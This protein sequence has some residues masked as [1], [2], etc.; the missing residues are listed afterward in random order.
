MSRYRGY[1]WKRYVPV[2][3]R[4][5]KAAKKL[6]KLRKDGLDVRPVSI[7]G[8]KIART[9]WGKAWC[10]HLESF[11][12]FANRLPRGRTYVRNG[13]VCHLGLAKGEIT[14]L[15]SGSELYRVEVGIKTLATATWETIK[16]RCAGQIG[17]ILE[18]LQGRLSE[19]VMKIVSDR[20]GGLFPRP[21][22]IS[23]Q[24][25]CPDW[26]SMCKHV[27]AVLYGV[28]ARLDES[29]ELLFL[30]RGVDQGELIS[31]EIDLAGSSG[32]EKRGGK[33][34][35]E[36][37]L[38]DVFGIE[39]ADDEESAVPRPAAEASHGVSTVGESG[40]AAGSA[41]RGSDA[42]KRPPAAVASGKSPAAAPK[43][44]PTGVAR[45]RARSITASDV[46][47]LR[48]KL[49]LSR[50]ELARLLGVSPATVGNWEKRA[51]ALPLQERTRVALAAV[52]GLTKR[53]AR[54]ELDKPL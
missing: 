32:P 12:D 36:D 27:A 16:Q 52:K 2:A 40:A 38:A 22:E 50:T 33:R 6:E 3:E 29:P 23:F 34:I 1:G 15:V 46:V 53:Q 10:D 25:S 8:T 30:L 4:R 17:S 49:D 7:S 14:A 54:R 35:A 39:M 47:R 9:F 31:S 5:A 37:A 51:G 24:C 48:T 18:L 28:G 19:N 43:P 13:S 42:R 21:G 11:S 45:S 20:A 26:A 41:G 44:P